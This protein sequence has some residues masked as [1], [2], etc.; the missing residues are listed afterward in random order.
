MEDLK[1]HLNLA[2]HTAGILNY[3]LIKDTQW[4]WLT[5]MVAK[6]MAKGSMKELLTI[7]EAYLMKT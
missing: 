7:G 4:L 5:P 2:G 1:V 6:V 3:G